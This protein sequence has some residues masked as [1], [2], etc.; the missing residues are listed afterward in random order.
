ML[1]QHH[2]ITAVSS[3]LPLPAW[4]RKTAGQRKRQGVQSSCSVS[5]SAGGFLG[6][7]LLQRRLARWKQNTSQPLQAARKV[8][9]TKKSLRMGFTS[10]PGPE[11]LQGPFAASDVSRTAEGR[12][13][14]PPRFCNYCTVTAQPEWYHAMF[15]D[16]PVRDE[17]NSNQNPS[18]IRF[19]AIIYHDKIQRKDTKMH[20]FCGPGGKIFLPLRTFLLCCPG[21]HVQELRAVV[22]IELD[23][24]LC[25]CQAT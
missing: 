11:N 14:D 10:F 20:N 1:I 6:P 7:F 25:L 15:F 4:S 21:G 24:L 17:E 19:A 2:C 9:K 3:C 22:Q 5:M 16:C 13:G 23:W 18:I 8:R 12:K